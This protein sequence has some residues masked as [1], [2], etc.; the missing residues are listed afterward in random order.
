MSSDLTC[1][2]TK[3]AYYHNIQLSKFYGIILTFKKPRLVLC[4]KGDSLF[5]R[6]C[7]LTTIRSSF[8]NRV[9]HM[10]FL[11]TKRTRLDIYTKITLLKNVSVQYTDDKYSLKYATLKTRDLTKN[12]W[13]QR[14]CHFK[15]LH[16]LGYF[17]MS[18]KNLTEKSLH[19]IKVNTKVRINLDLTPVL[20]HN[21][22]IYL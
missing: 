18:K 2:A 13:A 1:P 19:F 6:F 10:S 5:T 8:S 15:I 4:S 22:S 17:R 9:T 7:L 12:I 21:S 20:K 11:N 16:F 3:T 14:F